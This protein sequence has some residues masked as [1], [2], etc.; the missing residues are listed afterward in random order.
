ME[1]E[2]F[3]G[4]PSATGGACQPVEQLTGVLE[5]LS[6]YRLGQGQGGRGSWWSQR[7]QVAG[8]EE[9][10]QVKYLPPYHQDEKKE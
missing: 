6:S 8:R 7:L 2:Q 4:S 9:E 5:Y 1:E 3:T 10:G